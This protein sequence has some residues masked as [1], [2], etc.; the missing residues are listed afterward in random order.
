MD[1]LIIG[2]GLAGLGCRPHISP[3]YLRLT[4]FGD[5]TY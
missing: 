4:P 1:I 5:D 2:A 3:V